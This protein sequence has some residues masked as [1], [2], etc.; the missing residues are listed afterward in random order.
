MA[1]VINRWK[2][3][4]GAGLLSLS[5]CGLDVGLFGEAAPATAATDDVGEGGFAGSS[6]SAMGGSG[7]GSATGGTPSTSATG[8]G[9]P[10]GG[11]GP[12]TGMGGGAPGAGGAGQGG[13]SASPV[14][15]PPCGLLTPVCCDKGNGPTCV[16][17]AL[18]CACDP[19]NPGDVCAFTNVCCD[20]GSGPVCHSNSESCSC[21]SMPSVCDFFFDVC[22]DK[23]Q[24]KQ[25]YANPAGCF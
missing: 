8:G 4:L 17:N 14:C 9:D 6:G 20:K 13:G 15:D 25:C 1:G 24:G 2:W 21:A 10:S 22:C 7:P 3:V 23:G 5:A 16:S 11:Q 19:T 18:G 12:S